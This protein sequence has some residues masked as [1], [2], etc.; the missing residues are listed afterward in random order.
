MGE[1]GLLKRRRDVPAQ[2]RLRPE[3]P[4]LSPDERR[5]YYHRKDAA[6]YVL[7][8]VTRRSA[9]ESGVRRAGAV[10]DLVSSAVAGG[11]RCVKP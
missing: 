11:M 6:R 2:D 10:I 7:Y 8:R 5:L 1:P 3:P 9:G 4:T